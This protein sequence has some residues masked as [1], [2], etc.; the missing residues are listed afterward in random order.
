MV[1]VTNVSET[2][3]KLNDLIKEAESETCSQTGLEELQTILEKIGA[4]QE[5]MPKYED[6]WDDAADAL[7]L[8]GITADQCSCDPLRKHVPKYKEKTQPD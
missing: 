2:K 7:M 6:I 3:A 8:A 1:D 5:L 4:N